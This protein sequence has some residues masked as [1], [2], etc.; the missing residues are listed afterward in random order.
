MKKIFLAVAAVAISI[1]AFA[2]S[3]SSGNRMNQHDIINKT[4]QDGNNPNTTRSGH[5]MNSQDPNVQNN[6]DSLMSHQ[7][8]RKSQ[9]DGY[10]MQNGKI[11]MSKNGRM[12]TMDKEMTFSDGSILMSDGTIIRKDGTK[13]MIK[14]G[15]YV[16]LTG[17]VVKSD[18][19]K[20]MYLVPDSTKNKK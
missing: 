2:Q 7:P 11:M 14:D 19:N 12:T 8:V 5:D 9:P 15:E 20:D 3:D 18:R 4:N 17:K 1:S 6:R 16:D 10:R 13:L